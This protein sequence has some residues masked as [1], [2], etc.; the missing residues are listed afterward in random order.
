MTT[1]EPVQAV[2]AA[3]SVR[4]NLDLIGHRC[5]RRIGKGEMCNC[6]NYHHNRRGSE[7]EHETLQC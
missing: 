2:P 3:L 6:Q 1:M 4:C 5:G 7:A